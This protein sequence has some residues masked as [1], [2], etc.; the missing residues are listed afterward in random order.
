M[1]KERKTTRKVETA[2]DFRDWLN[3][4]LF[5]GEDWPPKR[6]WVYEPP[7]EFIV[8]DG[9]GYAI[10][11]KPVDGRRHGNKENRRTY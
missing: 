9:S 8:I 11:N 6:F 4:Y 10:Y 5:Y 7:P 1:R 2:E 3:Y